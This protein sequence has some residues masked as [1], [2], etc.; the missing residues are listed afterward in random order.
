LQD[1][2]LLGALEDGL[3]ALLNI[4]VL[5]H[6]LVIKIRFQKRIEF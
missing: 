1:A 4:E 2:C 6:F 5:P 3:N